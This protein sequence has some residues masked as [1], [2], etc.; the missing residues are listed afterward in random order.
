MVTREPQP[1]QIEGYLVRIDP[2]T[3]AVV[4]DPVAVGVGPGP[5]VY[6]GG[7]VWVTLTS[8]SGTLVRVEPSAMAVTAKVDGVRGTPWYAAGKIWAPTDES[9]LAIDPATG[10]ILDEYPLP[11]SSEVDFGSGAVWLLT[12][13]GSTSSEFYIPDPRQ[14]ATVVEV[15]PGTGQPVG[16]PIAVGDS[17]SYLAVGEGAVWVAQ[18]DSGIITRIDPQP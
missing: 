18:Y 3:N 5:V 13:S 7:A 10:G 9:V 15:D 4:G 2:A 14:P 8:G 6:G 16:Q 11:P 12:R 1:D 17:P